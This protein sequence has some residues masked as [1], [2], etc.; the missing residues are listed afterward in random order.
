MIDPAFK[1]RVDLTLAYSHLRSEARRKI[2]V[3]FINRLPKGDVELQDSEIS[4]LADNRMN[5]REIKSAIKTAWILA[6]RDKPLRML[7]LNAVLDNRRRTEKMDLDFGEQRAE[8][9]L[10]PQN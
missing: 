5:G 8:S 3:N 7:H 9:G 4:E 10:T 6:A 2:W 1:S